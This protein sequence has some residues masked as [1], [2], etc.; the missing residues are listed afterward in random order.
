MPNEQPKGAYTYP[1]VPDDPDRTGVLRNKLSLTTHSELRPAE[2]ALTHI[3]QIEIAEGRG[4]S[5]NFDRAHLKA[6][7][8]YIFQDVYEWAGHT[9]NESPIVDGQR[10]EPIGGLSKGGSPFLP[11]S[12]IEMGLDEALK[13]IRDPQA[14]R[15]A[16]PEQFAERA[17]QV[18]A[19]LNYV[20]PFREGNGRAQEAFIS[21]LG[22]RY[23]HEIDFSVISKPRMIEASIETTNDPSSHAMKHVVQDA[24]DPNR[25]EAIRAAFAD[26][27]DCGEEPLQH[28]V[29]TARAGEEITGTV[30][31]VD[32]RLTSLVTDQGI[33]V[34]DRADLPERLP[35]D[36][37]ITFTA[38]SD[39]SR[40]GREQPAREPQSQPT[41]AGQPQQDQ[42]PE[43]KSIEAQMAAQRSRERD[44]N[45]HGR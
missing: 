39:F 14:L 18:L 17:G 20:H 25:R 3:R 19:E 28:N 12:R 15:N 45:D 8:G 1:D 41:P 26:L 37:E 7:H 36:E 44:D 34:A 16:T 27:K 10:V 13:P 43:L 24:M 11:G 6:I 23:G 40:L 38:R 30:L 29:R 9:R 2:Y 42:N 31:G 32:D 33:A 5:G 35:A 22:R 4:P 21:E